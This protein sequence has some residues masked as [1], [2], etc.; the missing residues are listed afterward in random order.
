MTS[1]CHKC[2][3]TVNMLREG[4]RYRCSKCGTPKA[5]FQRSNKNQSTKPGVLKSNANKRW[6]D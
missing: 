1:L 3:Q 4:N 2:L 5:Y 6:G